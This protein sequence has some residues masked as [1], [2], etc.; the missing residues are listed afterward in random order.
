MQTSP[1]ARYAPWVAMLGVAALLVAAAIAFVQ[2]GF[3]NNVQIALVVGLIIL[4]VAMVLDP[5]GLMRVLGGRQARYGA[6]ALLLTA[7]FG[8]ILI[9]LNY[10]AI[11]NPWQWDATENQVNTL[12]LETINAL[13]ALPG[14]VDV[15][16][17]YTIDSTT[18]RDNAR[19]LLDRLRAQA[20]DKIN[21]R[22]VD[23]QADPVATRTYEITQD[24]T[25]IFEMGD[26][27]Q[28]VAGFFDESEVTGALVRLASPTSRV[29]YFLTGQGEAAIE[30]GG[31]TSVSIWAGLLRDQNYDVR[32]LNLTVTNTVPAD[33]RALIIAG[34]V[35]PMTVEDVAKLQA[36]FSGTQDASLIVLLDPPIENP[37]E[38]AA[39]A[40]N[41]LLDYLRQSWGVEVRSDLVADLANATNSSQGPNPFQPVYFD[42]GQSPV[43]EGLSGRP[44]LFSNAR[45]ISVTGTI[46]T[47][48]YSPLVQTGVD[49]WGETDVNALVES[50]SFAAGEGDIPGPLTLALAV[51]DPTRRTRLVVVGDATLGTDQILSDVRLTNATFL[52]NAVNW[53]A[54][55][56]N[57]INLTPRTPTQRF[58]SVQNDWT[59]AVVL[60]GTIICLPGLIVL[61]GLGVWFVRRRHK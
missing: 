52:L 57:L 16:G 53:G 6:N 23:P 44:I 28:R 36:Y 51:E 33:A 13:N 47:V 37:D 61:A 7:A 8:G 25:L 43:T 15:I 3:T 18:Q 46:T 59:A 56:E 32:A 10:V 29:V 50:G 49:A 40:A 55:D 54:R 2:R 27:R 14:P 22:F 12:S 60:L 30:A 11:R 4:I 21:Y 41:P 17:F 20:P 39:I 58:L 26:Q 1:Y 9:A 34:P 35:I 45:S 19:R 48:T 5:N 42:F 24:Q 31:Q 38:Q